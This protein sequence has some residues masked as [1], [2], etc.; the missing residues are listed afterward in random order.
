[1][2]AAFVFNKVF[3]R[4][5]TM[6]AEYYVVTLDYRDRFLVC[7]SVCNK[8]FDCVLRNHDHVLHELLSKRADITYNLR[9]S[10]MTERSRRRGDI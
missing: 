2:R 9:T 3:G 5:R 10:L 8:L 4:I 7:L 6:L 1:M